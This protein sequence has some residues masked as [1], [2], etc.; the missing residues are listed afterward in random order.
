MKLLQTIEEV[1]KIFDTGGSSPLLV[2]CNDFNDWICKY[3]KFPN[4]LFNEL[5]A[6]EFAKIWGIKVPETALIKVKQEH[7]PTDML[8]R[9]QKNWFYKECFG[10]KYLEDSK[11]IDL[12]ILP[13]FKEKKFR[14]KVHDKSDFLKIALFD[15][16]LSNEDRNHNNFNLLLNLSP[17]KN[18]FFY[19]IDHV[20][21]FNTSLL[22][23]G[24]FNISEDDSIIKTDL[25]KILFSKNKKTK[26]IV[27]NLLE[28]FYLC[29]EE[30][31]NKLAEI[32]EKVPTSWGLNLEDIKLKLE[33]SIFTDDWKRSC[34]NN[35]REFVQSFIINQ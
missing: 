8:T 6:S 19:A 4:Y 11:E 23:Y 31:K 15:I 1:H 24:L 32:F 17:E 29:I 25:A 20:N 30:C 14:D 2:T 5:L 12:S 10:S 16:W 22:D 35:F 34:D 26:Q 28:N 21:I 27:T 3:D 13:L 33:N 7:I 18:Y 9:L